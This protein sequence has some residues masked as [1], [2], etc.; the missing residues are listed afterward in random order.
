MSTTPSDV[1]AVAAANGDAAAAPPA[2]VGD[3]LVLGLPAF[4]T[5]SIALGLALVGYIPAA[6]QA[7]VL[8]IL[9]ATNSLGLLVA[10]IWATRLDQ[11]F[12]AGLL[13]IFAGFWLSY[14]ILSLGLGHNWFGV[15]AEDVADTV[16]LFLFSWTVII[17][18][19]TIVSVRLPSAY[20]AMLAVVDLALILLAIG[21]LQESTGLTKAGGWVVLAFAAIGVYLFIGA[22][23]AS[24][25]GKGLP[26]G[27]P[28]VH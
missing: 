1:P 27:K 28:L 11:T 6:A 13:G 25:G 23:S 24:V 19:F 9:I 16:G 18:A 5:G 15:P 20:T 2:P 3:P 14:S 26:L 17:V 4:A 12:V 7:G 8:P 21:T 10:A 22:A